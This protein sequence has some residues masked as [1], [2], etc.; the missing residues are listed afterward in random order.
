MHTPLKN[1]AM[2]VALA[3]GGCHFM[4]Q[5][6][7]QPESWRTGRGDA[8]VEARGGGAH[9]G[10]PSHRLDRQIDRRKYTK[11]K[12]HIGL[13]WL[14]KSLYATTNQKHVETA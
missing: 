5:H 9:G 7:N 14:I 4:I 1:R 3:L 6:H 12:I 11:N 13:R 10:M 8:R 2:A